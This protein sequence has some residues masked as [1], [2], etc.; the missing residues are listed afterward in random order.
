MINPIRLAWLHL[1]LRYLDAAIDGIVANRRAWMRDPDR[2]LDSYLDATH[3][4]R[5]VA[6]KLQGMG[7]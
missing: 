4:R 5:V 3:A 1:R 7:R 2:W 6:R